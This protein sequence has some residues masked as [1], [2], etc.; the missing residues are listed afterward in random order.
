[1]QGEQLL[2]GVFV[3]A[4]IPRLRGLIGGRVCRRAGVVVRHG[5]TLRFP[6]GSLFIAARPDAPGLW[7]SEETHEMA[8]PC[9]PAWQDHLEGAEVTDVRQQGADRVVVLEMESAD[10]YSTGQV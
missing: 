1:M 5:L 2:E 10:P 7:W 9:S 8:P 4:L 3:S 6:H